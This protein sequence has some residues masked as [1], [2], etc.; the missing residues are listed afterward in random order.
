MYELWMPDL[1]YLAFCSLL[2][3]GCVTHLYVLF[4]IVQGVKVCDATMLNSCSAVRFKNAFFIH[5]NYSDLK[6]F[7]GF[8]NAAFIA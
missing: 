2:I 7:T 3:A 1:L 4:N 5:D 8:A 6:L